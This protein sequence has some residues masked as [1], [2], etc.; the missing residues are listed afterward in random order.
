MMAVNLG[1]RGPEEARNLVEYCNFK[2]G[3]YYSDLRRAN[4]F[5]EPFGIKVW[6]LGNEMDGPWQMGMKTATEYGRIAC[7]AAKLMKW[8]DPSI[9]LV[10]CVSS[11]SGVCGDWEAEVLKKT[12][13]AL[14]LSGHTHAAQFRLWG[15]TPASWMFRQ[16]AGRY[17]SDGQTIYVNAGIGCTMPM[18]INCPSEITLITLHNN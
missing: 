2:S 3:T 4:G 7:E 1:T 12:D 9:E 13:I 14:T 18:R 8:T 15:W 5:E 11:G 16:A 17:D 6:C 10:V